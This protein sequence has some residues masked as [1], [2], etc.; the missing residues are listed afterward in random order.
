M[1]K[2]T[3]PI[4]L[5]LLLFTLVFGGPAAQ[6][7]D[8]GSESRA[9]LNN[10]SM[11]ESSL[12]KV[13]RARVLLEDYRNWPE[14]YELLRDVLKNDETLSKVARKKL[15]NAA[16]QVK[17][18]LPGRWFSRTFNGRHL[19][20]PFLEASYLI[21]E[22]IMDS[23]IALNTSSDSE[24]IFAE[25][26]L[27]SYFFPGNE[28]QGQIEYPAYE[29]YAFDLYALTA[30]NIAS[31]RRER[32]DQPDSD[33]PNK[34]E[35]E[36]IPDT[37]AS[38]VD[39]DDRDLTRRY[40]LANGFISEIID[41]G[42]AIAEIT[43]EVQSLIKRYEVPNRVHNRYLPV[44]ML[45]Q[46]I[47]DPG[48]ALFDPQLQSFLK[49]VRLKVA[50]G[51]S[52]K[53]GN[54]DLMA[55]K[56]LLGNNAI[57]EKAG[58]TRIR[59]GYLIDK[60]RG[61]PYLKSGLELS[62][63][64][65]KGSGRTILYAISAVSGEEQ[66][67][68]R[69]LQMAATIARDADRAVKIGSGVAAAIPAL[70]KLQSLGSLSLAKLLAALPAAANAVNEM[71]RPANSGAIGAGLK[72]VA[73]ALKGVVS[74]QNV[75]VKVTSVLSPKATQ[76]LT[77]AK[78]NKYVK[79]G[80]ATGVLTL[81]VAASQITVGVIEYRASDDQDRKDEIYV[82]TLSRVGATASYML[83]VV[84]W[85]A[86]ALDLGHAFLGVPVETADLFKGYSWAVGATTL[87]FMGTS[88]T[89]VKMVEI[90]V[91]LNIARHDVFFRR[92]E[93]RAGDT[94]ESC[95]D[96]LTGLRAETQS[97]ALS[98]LSFLYIAHRT[99]AAKTNYEFGERIEQH[100]RSYLNNRKA[101]EETQK[102]IQKK[103]DDQLIL[104]VSDG[105]AEGSNSDTSPVV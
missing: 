49:G 105:G 92:W 26:L 38:R 1:T 103:L 21:N 55:L 45:T 11:V 4:T 101:A 50:L 41:G 31:A 39:L 59:L 104:E 37:T 87:W 77:A 32:S 8:L 14:S 40:S 15:Q 13:Y 52:D 84:G 30:E 78:N 102:A 88:E 100:F 34:D 58:E 57:V 90:E 76:L 22:A 33:L 9:V 68:I 27:K 65:V 75:G 54:D 19:L 82:D 42:V 20:R 46:A 72:S 79:N 91:G 95:H 93:K 43:K 12:S 99:F 73:W 85:A 97:L 7:T 2:R 64:D 29:T 6:A 70:G 16:G 53:P 17:S 48:T 83:P 28:D 80:T 36:Q 18:Y 89:E 60:Q 63:Q 62:L 35:S 86:A 44:A 24:V 94:I 71:A 67:M 5:L 3:S 51:Q 25:M 98:E 74:L 66:M 23:R 81:V 56:S 96:A 61:N 10:T 47:V 69:T